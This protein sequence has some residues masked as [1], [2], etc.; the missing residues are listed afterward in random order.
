[1]KRISLKNMKS[2]RIGLLV[3]VFFAA[4]AVLGGTAYAATSVVL[5]AGTLTITTP[6]VAN[7]GGLTLNGAA[8]TT[9]A[10]LGT[11]TVTDARGSGI[12][13]NVTVQATQFTAGSH[14]L[15]MNSIS[16]PAPTVAKADATSGNVPT[17]ATGPYLIDNATAVKISSAAVDATT[18]NGMGSYTYTPGNLTL[19]VPA[20]AYAGTY[21]ST[22][23]VSVVTG[24]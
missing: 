22:V 15:A 9:T 4:T 10:A 17:I 5:S 11:F 14:T 7:F 23:T 24:P 21:T 2:R 18:G 3:G 13:W 19:S 6:S 1:M 16:M 12:G 20:N 8:Q